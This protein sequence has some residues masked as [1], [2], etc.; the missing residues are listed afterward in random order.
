MDAGWDPTAGFF[1]V[2]IVVGTVNI[3]SA[4]LLSLIDTVVQ[5]WLLAIDCDCIAIGLSFESPP[6][7]RDSCIA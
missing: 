6:I 1:S 4:K 7:N 3:W 5:H 2:L